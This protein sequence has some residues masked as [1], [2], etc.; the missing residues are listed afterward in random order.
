MN[1]EETDPKEVYKVWNTFK[2]APMAANLQMVFYKNKKND[3]LVKF[4]HNENEVHIPINTNNFP[5]YQWKDVRTYL[6][7][8]TNPQ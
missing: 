4:L 6:D 7:K 3:V 8:L 1:G 5:F 2:A